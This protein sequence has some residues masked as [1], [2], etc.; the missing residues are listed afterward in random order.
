MANTNLIRVAVGLESMAGTVVARA[1]RLPVTDNPGLDTEVTKERDPAINAENMPSGFHTTKLVSGGAVPLSFR[2]SPG[3]I[4]SAYSALGGTTPVGNGV[5]IGAVIRL[6]YTG[7]DASCKIVAN[8]SGDTLSSSK[9][10]YGAESAD[11]AFG[12]AGVIGLTAAAFNTVGE[13]V[14]AINAYADYACEK[15]G[16]ADSVDSANIVGIVAGQGKDRWVYIFFTSVSSGAYLYTITAHLGTTERPTLSAQVDERPSNEVYSGCVANQLALEAALQGF[17]SAT[18]TIQAF[19]E[20]A[21][22]IVT[23]N[24]TADPTVTEIDTRK[25]IAGMTVSGAHITAGTTIA[26][27]TTIAEEGELELSVAGTG[28][29]TGESLTFGVPD[30]AA[31]LEDIDPMVFWKG[32]TTLKATE[33]PFVN[34]ITVAVGNNGRE[35][36]FGQGKAS[37]QYNQKGGT[38]LTGTIQIPLDAAAYANRALIFSGLRVGISFYFYGKAIAASV[39]EMLIVDAPYCEL[40]NMTRPKNGDQLD[41]EYSWTAIAPKGGYYGSPARLYFISSVNM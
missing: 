18:L 27:I 25:L 38:D 36:T 15:L 23:G 35:D 29:G 26:S 11:A 14:A 17:V 41:A 12:T 8:T 2:P 9:G 3:C 7:A 4:L 39:K 40:M 22:T 19:E 32:S 28:T 5:Q 20:Y 21:D 10:V 33:Y 16:G 34:N 24:V 30:I 6:R 31:T 1:Y 13:L 37:R